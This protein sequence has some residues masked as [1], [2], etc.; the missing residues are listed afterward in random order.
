MRGIGDAENAVEEIPVKN[1]LLSFGC[2]PN[3]RV[4]ARSTIAVDYFV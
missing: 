3:M 2:P 4:D 1:A